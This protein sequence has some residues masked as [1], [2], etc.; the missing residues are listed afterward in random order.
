M[1]EE[2]GNMWHTLQKEQMDNNGINA[3]YDICSNLHIFIYTFVITV[4]RVYTMYTKG[5]GI[6]SA[7][8]I[9]TIVLLET[10]FLCEC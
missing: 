4:Y 8:G 1:D 5:M 9:H 3:E 10:F 7:K 6:V 2:W